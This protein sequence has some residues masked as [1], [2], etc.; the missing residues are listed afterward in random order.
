MVAID[1][2]WDRKKFIM[3]R[4]IHIKII[5]QR[6]L[7]S[8]TE[9]CNWNRNVRGHQA[10]FPCF[11]MRKLSPKNW[12]TAFSTGRQLS[13]VSKPCQALQEAEKEVGSLLV[14]LSNGFYFLAPPSQPLM[15]KGQ[16]QRPRK[17][18]SGY[19]ILLGVTQGQYTRCPAE[20]EF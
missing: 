11:T 19:G 16:K 3:L 6:Q 20:S 15:I 18:A 12:W 9:L 7:Y 10:Q 13:C 14:T 1:T 8:F 17:L 2:T 5:M 4:I